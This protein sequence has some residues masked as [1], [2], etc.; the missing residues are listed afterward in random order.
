MQPQNWTPDIPTPSQQSISLPQ[1]YRR[2]PNPPPALIT[3]IIPL[4]FPL[5]KLPHL[6]IAVVAKPDVDQVVAVGVLKLEVGGRVVGG[7]GVDGGG[8]GAVAVPAA[9]GDGVRGFVVEGC[10]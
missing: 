4:H 5:P 10:S 8:E 1:I 7:P 3:L 2:H 6:L 9:E